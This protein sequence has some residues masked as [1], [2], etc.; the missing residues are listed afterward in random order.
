MTLVD[1][2]QATVSRHPGQSAVV[3]ADRR[4][5]YA[6]LDASSARLAGGLTGMSLGKGAHVALLLSHTPD[7]LVAFFA[8]LK[9]GG[10]PIIPNPLLTGSEL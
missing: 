3:Q 2:L 1:A 6:E 9:A 8:V 5:S 7:W 4:V 10:T